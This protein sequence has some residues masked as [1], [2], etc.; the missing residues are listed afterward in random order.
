MHLFPGE[1]EKE[2]EGSTES[3]ASSNSSPASTQAALN[4]IQ[5]RRRPKRRSTGV[6]HV[7]MDVSTT[8]YVQIK[9]VQR[10]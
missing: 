1:D 6:G 5:R 2:R 9:P 8:L 7:D 4:V 3:K 10:Y